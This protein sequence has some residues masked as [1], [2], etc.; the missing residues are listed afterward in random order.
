MP[1]LQLNHEVPP[2]TENPEALPSHVRRGKK[3]NFK[4]NGN[5]NSKAL[6]H[7][8]E[9][10]DPSEKMMIASAYFGIYISTLQCHLSGIIL[11]RSPSTL[12]LRRCNLL[13]NRFTWKL[14]LPKLDHLRF[15]YL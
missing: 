14:F 8:I 15:P 10:I 4:K 5:W 6:T 3:E 11:S 2:P 1:S 12:S 7:A 9:A 13:L